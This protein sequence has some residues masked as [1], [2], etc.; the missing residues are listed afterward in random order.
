MIFLLSYLF[1]GNKIYL[2][3][4]ITLEI[5]KWTK[6]IFVMFYICVYTH[7]HICLY[8]YMFI[9]PCKFLYYI[10]IYINKRCFY[11]CVLMS[12]MSLH[13]HT[14][15]HTHTRVC[16]HTHFSLLIALPGTV[17]LLSAKVSKCQHI[18]FWIKESVWAP[19]HYSL[20]NNSFLAVIKTVLKDCWDVLVVW[21]ALPPSSE[22]KSFI[23][24]LN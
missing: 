6:S 13:I 5:K 22:T 14:Y 8:I 23:T 2:H 17:V 21:R 18:Y 10:Y 9:Y 19:D 16:T 12:F 7:R 1:N 11:H 15:T 3:G 4:L 20:T 24:F